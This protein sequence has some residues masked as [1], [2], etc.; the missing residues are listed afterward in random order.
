[1]FKASRVHLNEVEESYFEHLAAALRIALLMVR[2][3]TACALHG[4]VPGLCTRT[5]TECVAQV[6]RLLARRE[7]A[8]SVEKG[9]HR[10]QGR[11][12]GS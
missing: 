8:R 12:W 2:A 9:L 4:L 3:G 6:Q 7:A 11:L 5:A 1:M 10:A